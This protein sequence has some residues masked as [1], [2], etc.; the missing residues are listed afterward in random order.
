LRTKTN[1]LVHDDV[2]RDRS[3]HGQDLKAAG[4]IEGLQARP[5]AKDPYSRWYPSWSYSRAHPVSSAEAIPARRCEWDD[6]NALI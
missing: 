6:R 4:A 1:G 2:Q 5:T 3:A